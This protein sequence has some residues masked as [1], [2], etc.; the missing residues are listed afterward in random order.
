M[1]MSI[2]DS[3]SSSRLLNDFLSPSG[4]VGLQLDQ[5]LDELRLAGGHGADHARNLVVAQVRA[6]AAQERAG[7]GPEE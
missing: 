5:F 7:A 4:Q 2:A 3:Y 1:T 6:L